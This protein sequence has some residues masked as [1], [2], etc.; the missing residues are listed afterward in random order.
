MGGK[1]V[2]ANIEY[3]K[4]RDTNGMVLFSGTPEEIAVMLK[5]D[6]KEVNH[7]REC[8]RLVRNKY[9]IELDNDANTVPRSVKEHL[10]DEFG[11]RRYEWKP[12]MPNRYKD[13]SCRRFSPL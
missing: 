5:I 9:R 6:V 8:G 10:F 2:G 1:R 12:N 7:S 4:V 13:A 3:L 11:N